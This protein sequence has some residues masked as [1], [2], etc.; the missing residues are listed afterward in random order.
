MDINLVCWNYLNGYCPYGITCQHFHPPFPIFPAQLANTFLCPQPFMPIEPVNWYTAICKHFKEKRRCPLGQGCRFIHDPTVMKFKEL[1]PR[2]EN[3]ARHCWA[4]VQGRKCTLGSCSFSHPADTQ[5]FKKYTPC[6]AWPS[7]L[8]GCEFK[9]P[10]SVQASFYNHQAPN[11]STIQPQPAPT[12]VR[13]R[14]A[15]TNLD[16]APSF[17]ETNDTIDAISHAS[18]SPVIC[19]E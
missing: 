4:Y 17:M 6:P 5:P 15:R 10:I 14:V 9:H 8:P 2:A 3:S 7:C 16:S 18:T 13:V 12:A 1:N 19:T 11:L